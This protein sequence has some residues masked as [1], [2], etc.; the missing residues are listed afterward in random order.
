MHCSRVRF[1]RCQGY[2]VDLSSTSLGLLIIP[3]IKKKNRLPNKKTDAPV[4]W[5]S[6]SRAP[7]I[8]SS[9]LVLTTWALSIGHGRKSNED[10]QT[11]WSYWASW[12]DEERY[13]IRN[14]TRKLLMTGIL[15]M[16]MDSEKLPSAVKI[17][18][19]LIQRSM[20]NGSCRLI[21]IRFTWW[22]KTSLVVTASSSAGHLLIGSELSHSFT[23][24]VQKKWTVL[25]WQI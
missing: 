19:T 12:A 24:S 15:S 13:K 16:D 5:C 20:M 1:C 17:T 3:K 4:F 11:V 8:T 21:H 25:L 18:Q 22:Y 14:I 23:L 2:L 7:L 6:F 9:Y 10:K